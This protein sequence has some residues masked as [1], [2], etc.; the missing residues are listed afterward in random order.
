MIVLTL[1][2]ALSAVFVPS[3]A[4]AAAVGADNFQGAPPLLFSAPGSVD[5]TQPY[6]TQGALEPAPSSGTPPPA[7]PAMFHTAWWVITG[8]GQQINVTTAGSE[9]NT[10]L[11]VYDHG[12]PG[13][14]PLAGNRKACDEDSGPGVLS[15]LSFASVRGR[16]YLVQAGGTLNSEFGKLA[17]TASSPVRPANDDRIAAQVLQT[18]MPATV[19]NV[20]A[21]QELDENLT[22]ATANYAATIWFRWTAPAIGDAAFSAS[23]AFG[24]TVVTVYR[25]SDGALAGCS[26]AA[27]PTVPLRVMAGDYLVQVGTKGVDAPGLGEGAITVAAAFVEDPDLDNDG[28]LRS[29]DC[30]D[31]DPTIRPGIADKP[32]DGIDQ[33]CD[34]VDAVNL[35][36]DGDGYNRPG[37]CNDANPRIHPQARDIPGNKVDEDCTD[38]PAPYPRLNSRVVSFFKYP[39][40]RFTTLTVVQGIK[41]SRIELRCRGGGRDAR[42]RR[43]P[44][45]RSRSCFK[46]KVVR[47]RK[48]R[49]R[50]SLLRYVRRARLKPGTVVEVRITKAD[51]VGVM[52]R[53][54]VRRAGRS[55]RIADLCLPVGKRRPASC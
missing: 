19:S 8:T 34:G 32:D 6:T 24:E 17:V 22:C 46:R 16:Q 38:G 36:R 41:G 4:A 5:N 42:S 14:T 50:L 35:D 49:A 45:P 25:G 52:R 1:A 11:A 23:A 10:T 29:V 44:A 27:A 48:S 15:A 20:G 40:L 37:D 3:A 2:G 12:G 30:N 7:C 28:A 13:G 26:A 54:T 18:A 47:V 43:R 21:S 51:H 9:F 55:P 33:N 53:I 31:N 39:P